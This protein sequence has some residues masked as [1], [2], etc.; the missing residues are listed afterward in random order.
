M[1]SLIIALLQRIQY[2]MKL[3]RKLGGFLFIEA[4]CQRRFKD[5]RG[6][7]HAHSKV[8]LPCG[9][10]NAI[11][12]FLLPTLNLTVTKKLPQYL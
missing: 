1:D 5:V 2:M 6:A 8:W 9:T 10:P 11:L 4:P 12:H 7:V 3:R